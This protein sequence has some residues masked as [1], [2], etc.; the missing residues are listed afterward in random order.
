MEGKESS[1][2][3]DAPPAY[4]QPPPPHVVGQPQ[5]GYPQPVVMQPQQSSVSNTTVVV[6]QAAAPAHKPLRSWTTGLCGCFE[7][8]GVCKYEVT[9]LLVPPSLLVFFTTSDRE[10]F[11]PNFNQPAAWTFY[12]FSGDHGKS[13]ENLK[14]VNELGLDFLLKKACIKKKQELKTETTKTAQ[15]TKKKIQ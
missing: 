3:S 7:D 11:H 12:V 4:S 5:W 2:Q 8:C 14:K 15:R 6:N 10:F 9:Q 13:N 1:P